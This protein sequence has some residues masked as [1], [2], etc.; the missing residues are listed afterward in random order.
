[1][2]RSRVLAVL[3]LL[4]AVGMAIEAVRIAAGDRALLTHVEGR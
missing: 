3:L 4:V 1:M 2:S